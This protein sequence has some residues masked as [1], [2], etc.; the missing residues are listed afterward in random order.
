MGVTRSGRF[1]G[2]D[3]QSLVRSGLLTE[4]SSR[5]RLPHRSHALPNSAVGSVLLTLRWFAGLCTATN[6]FYFN[7]STSKP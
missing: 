1:A 7:M 5:R 3:S 2:S 4:V 6:T